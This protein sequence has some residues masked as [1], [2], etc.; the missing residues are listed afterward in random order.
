MAG[1]K[2]AE[3]QAQL[4]IGRVYVDA[5]LQS[6]LRLA[7]VVDAF[8]V[9]NPVLRL[10]HLGQGRYDVDDVIAKL[11]APKDEAQTPPSTEPARLALYNLLLQGGRVDLPTTPVG[12][13]HSVQ[14]LLL[15]GAFHQHAV[16]KKEVRVEPG[17]PS[18]WKAAVL[19]RRPKARRL[20]KP[21]TPTPTSAGMTWTWRPTWATC[22]PA[23][24]FSSRRPRWT[25]T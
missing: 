21:G 10:T 24:P 6:V 3:G 14:D 22:P 5:E 4:T 25:W 2:G 1:A 15:S 12:K 18:R 17:W 8:T 9:E 20:R 19:T 11:A 7:P 23:C 16:D 13:T